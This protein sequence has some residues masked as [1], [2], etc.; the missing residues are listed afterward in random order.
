MECDGQL[1]QSCQF[2]NIFLYNGNEWNKFSKE[3]DADSV[4]GIHR[5]K[6]IGCTIIFMIIDVT[7]LQTSI[8]QTMPSTYS[9]NK[10]GTLYYGLF[11]PNNYD[12]SKK[13]PLITFLHGYNDT[14]TKYLNWYTNESQ[15]KNPCFVVSPKSPPSYGDW[16]GWSTELT[17]PAKNVLE[18]IDTLSAQFNIDK[19]RLYIY[20]I[21]L[22]GEGVFDI[23]DKKPGYFAAAMS[24]CGGGRSAWAG[25][26]SKTPFWIF[27]GSA[28]NVNPPSLSKDVYIEMIRQGAKKVR[29]QE[30]PGVGHNVWDYAPFELS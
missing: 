7:C 22:G 24:L 26:I 20:G 14:L 5:V 2:R 1:Q 4:K 23:L 28:D 29:Y 17:T 3:D 16:S 18:L 19:S 13:Y 11:K 12:P 6:T 9:Y 21:S 15:S 8:A 10:F 30:Y 27:H 25:N